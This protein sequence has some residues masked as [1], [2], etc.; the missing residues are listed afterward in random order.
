MDEQVAK[1][2]GLIEHAELVQKTAIDARRT[3]DAGAE[4]VAASAEAARRSM[5]DA[6]TAIDTRVSQAVK[7]ALETQL[8]TLPADLKASLTESLSGPSG[9]IRAASDDL[10]RASARLGWKQTAV[11]AAIAFSMVLGCVLV[12]WW[13]VPS[14]AAMQQL[15]DEHAQLVADNDRLSRHGVLS[16]CGPQGQPCVRVDTSQSYGKH[17]DYFVLKTQGD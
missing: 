2:V 6:A 12:W 13:L 3:L 7:Q 9:S 16:T 15:R 10:D 11:A 1:L 8:K 17:A 14:A 4:K 5:V